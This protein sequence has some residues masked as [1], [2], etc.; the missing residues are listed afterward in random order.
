MRLRPGFTG[1]FT[2]AVGSHHLPAANEDVSVP[3]FTPVVGEHDVA[4]SVLAEAVAFIEF[5]VR[6]GTIPARRSGAFIDRQLTVDPVSNSIALNENLTHIELATGVA[7]RR[8]GKGGEHII[9][10]CRELLTWQIL[11]CVVV[12]N[13]ILAP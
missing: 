7:A 11:K 13:L 12:E 8:T 5:T 3:H 4:V 2:F 6:N 1:T 9:Q 10:R